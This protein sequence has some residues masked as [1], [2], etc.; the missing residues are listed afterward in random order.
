MSTLSDAKCRWCRKAGKKLMLKGEKCNSP[1]CALVSRNYPPGLHGSKKQ[2][3]KA[4]QYSQQL[5]EKQKAKRAYGMRERQFRLMFERAGRKGEAGENLLKMLE[6]RLDNVIYR[7]GLAVSRPEARQMVSHGM[8]TV[9]G[10]AVNIPSYQV[11]AGEIIAIKKNKRH[12]KTFT[13]LMDKLKKQEVPGW[14]YFKAED[15]EGKVLHAPSNEDV[16]KSLNIQAIV[17]FYSK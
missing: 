17:E 10:V 7:F 13:N 1:K 5:A 14:L 15:M 11:K 4:S 9:N 6:S 16:D 12:K 8:F 2:R 3:G